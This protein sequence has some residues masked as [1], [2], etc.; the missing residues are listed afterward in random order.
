MVDDSVLIQNSVQKR[1]C[2]ADCVCV[3]YNIHK[4]DSDCVQLQE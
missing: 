3:R 1:M 2:V 4:K